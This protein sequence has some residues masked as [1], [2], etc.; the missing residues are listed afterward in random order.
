MMH[1]YGFT[2]LEKLPRECL[3]GCSLMYPSMMLWSLCQGHGKTTKTLRQAL[4]LIISKPG[5]PDSQPHLPPLEPA[6][7]T[8]QSLQPAKKCSIK[9]LNTLS[10]CSCTRSGG[11]NLQL[12]CSWPQLYRRRACGTAARVKS[13]ISRTRSPTR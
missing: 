11:S 4:N 10:L 7:H 9:V 8:L 13:R 2:F 5:T 1:P 3:K 6:V 12:D